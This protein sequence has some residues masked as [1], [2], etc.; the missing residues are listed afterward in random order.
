MIRLNV[1]A[2][3][4]RDEQVLLVEFDDETGLHYN[5]PGGGVEEGETLTDAVQRE[6][7]EEAGAKVDVGRLLLVWEYVPA[8]ENFKYGTTHKVGLIYECVLQ[9]GSEPH[10]TPQHDAHQTGVGWLPVAKLAEVETV[11]YFGEQLLHA[12]RHRD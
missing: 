10:F 12:L 4:V 7:W 6:A 9:A 3:I 1:A 11:K 2:L 5:L 8:R